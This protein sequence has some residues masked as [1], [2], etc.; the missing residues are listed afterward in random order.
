MMQGVR[1]TSFH[2]PHTSV[3]NKNSSAKARNLGGDC[4]PKREFEVVNRGIFLTIWFGPEDLCIV[5]KNIGMQDIDA[6]ETRLVA[7][8]GD[9]N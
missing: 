4:Y 6:A 8:D 1:R 7:T 2:P 5:D 9:G 3:V